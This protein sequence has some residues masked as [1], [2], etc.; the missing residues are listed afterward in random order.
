MLTRAKGSV[1]GEYTCET[2]AEAVFADPEIDAVVVATPAATHYALTTAALEAGKHVLCEKPMTTDVGEAEALCALAG[3]RGLKLMVGHTF[4][5]NNSVLKVK[6]LVD[7]GRVG[8]LYYLVSTRTHMGLVRNDVSVLWDLAPHDVAIMNHLTGSLPERVSAVAVH[9][10]GLK[11]PDVAF[12]HLF[13]PDGLIG[14]IQVSWIDSHKERRMRVI[15]DMGQAIF[16]DIDT[17]E[18][19]RFYE[20]SVNVGRR[21]ATEF[22][23]YTLLLRDGDIVSPKVNTREPLSQM[24]DA[25]VQMV[26]DDA[27]CPSDGQ[28]GL[29]ITRTL[30]AAHASIELSGAPVAVGGAD[31]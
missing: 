14:S 30:C 17:L 28:S 19:V 3:E 23:E 22:G 1:M 24:I 10:L 5:F 4:L 2:S 18:P 13:Y 6:E 9:P 8:K 21:A 12:I 15:G 16:N 11:M 26:L 29:E 20:K 25:F 27:S 7:T 31:E